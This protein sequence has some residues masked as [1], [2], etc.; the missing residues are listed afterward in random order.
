MEK[1]LYELTEQ[2]AY[3]EYLLEENGGELTPEIEAEMQE[4]EESL[5]QKTDGYTAVVRKF[6]SQSNTI[7]EEI[8][9]L[10]ALK[11]TCDNSVKRIKEHLLNCMDT[12]GIDKLDGELSKIY[13][14][15][16][17]AVEVNEELVFAPYLESIDEFKATLPANL[18]VEVKIK[19][20]EVNM[21]EAPEGF[22]QVQNTSVILK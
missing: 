17:K 13:L 20:S 21:D 7:A 22:T 2:M 12:F 15:R 14:R 10:Q 19:K 4:T 5:K 16:S 11:K 3:I 9:R 8:K 1:K 18:E 6:T